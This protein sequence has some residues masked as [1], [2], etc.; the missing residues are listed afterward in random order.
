MILN[1]ELPWFLAILSLLFFTYFTSIII[2]YITHDDMNFWLDGNVE[3]LG[4][5]Y[6]SLGRV[7]S[8]A[9]LHLFDHMFN[10]KIAEFTLHIRSLLIFIDA[11]SCFIFF[12]IIR[13]I[14]PPVEA[15][16]LSVCMFTLPGIGGVINWTVV[17]GGIF[18]A[19]FA[20][21]SYVAL[22]NESYSKKKRILLSMILRQ[23]SLWTYTAVSPIFV[24]PTL[25]KIFFL[26]KEWEKNR[27]EAILVIKIYLAS[28]MLY[29]LIIKFLVI[30]FLK[31]HGLYIP[32]FN[33]S[34][35]FTIDF[36]LIDKIIFFSQE[37]FN[38]SNLW[39]IYPSRPWSIVTFIIIIFGGYFFCKKNGIN[40]SY[41]KKEKIEI[42]KKFAIIGALLAITTIPFMGPPHPTS[43]Y[44]V[45]IPVMMAYFFILYLACKLIWS[46]NNQYLV[47]IFFVPALFFAQFNN[48]NT[49]LNLNLE[50]NYIKAKISEHVK[51]YNS[52]ER[53][54]FV[55][56]P[57]GGLSYL[58]YPLKGGKDGAEFN[59][60]SLYEVFYGNVNLIFSEAA[61]KRIINKA[62]REISDKMPGISYADEEMKKNHSIKV[63]WGET[64]PTNIAND[65]KTLIIDMNNLGIR[66][67]NTIQEFLQKNN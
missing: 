22:T 9:M 58:G 11:I 10:Y 4:N 57:A 30:P 16:L 8:Y 49:A 5:Y 61:K 41:I 34:Q 59:S 52:L 36:N 21:L 67:K 27:K 24:I 43:I 18:A 3:F 19:P 1:R 39:N 29:Y 15:L 25:I 12:R 26:P 53:I 2:P 31:A 40:F 45:Y 14:F 63:T 44:R 35:T 38:I 51:Q 66:G 64:A 50:Y 33:P 6:L 60:N 65:N 23:I 62:H 20:L 7:G 46:N 55:Q 42:A 54:H 48:L 28:V 37:I 13:K 56:I 47:A 17:S 32:P